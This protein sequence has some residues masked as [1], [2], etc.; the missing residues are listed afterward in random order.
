MT[1]IWILAAL[2]LLA[3]GA[4]VGSAV[5]GVRGR[6]I[7]ASEAEMRSRAE[8]AR[9][10]GVGSV[11]DVLRSAPVVIDAQGVVVSAPTSAYGT[12][13]VA[14]RRLAVPE[15]NRLAAAVRRDGD[16]RETELAVPAPGGSERFIGARV[17][18]LDRGRVLMLL[19]DRTQ[20]RRV[21][22]VRRDFVANVSHE[23]KTPVG[24][25]RL[26]SEAVQDA[27]EDPEAVQ[28]FAQRMHRESDRLTALVQRIIDLSRLQSDDP[29]SEPS[30]VDI[31]RVVASVIDDHSTDAAA[32]QI[33]IAHGGRRGLQVYGDAEQ[34]ALAVGNLVSNAIAYSPD[35]SRVALS[36]RL[37]DGQVELAV[38]D[39]GIGIAPEDQDR[40]FERF[41][42]C[43][44]ARQRST[45]GSGLGLSIVKHV[46]ASHGGDVRLWSRPDEGS[47]FT[48]SFPQHHAGGDAAGTHADRADEADRAGV[49]AADALPTLTNQEAP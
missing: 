49:Q 29:L 11:L 26:L 5:A 12:G 32:R 10:Q 45:G 9:E 47:T 33:Q 25:I 16:V 34:V 28:R 31:D 42:R 41:Y 46:M 35:S 44:P 17:G 39:Q 14:G 40:I 21:E 37:R 38:S 30:L 1:A 3:A 7:R 22:A 4:A 48:L 23:L 36:A 20:Q 18:L 27:A 19:D 6:A 8:Q 15:L 13:I 2:G 43:D 24:A